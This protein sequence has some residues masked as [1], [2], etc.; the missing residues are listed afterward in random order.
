MINFFK[1]LFSK[2]QKQAPQDFTEEEY[3][4]G[5]DLKSKG[6]ENVLGRMHNLVGHALIPFSVGGAV[7]M[8]YFLNH[9]KGT[10]FATMELLEPDG[11]GPLP[12]RLGTYELVAFTKHEYDNNEDSKGA[13]NIIERKICG[14][15]TAIGFYSREAVL[16]PYDTCELPNGDGKEN[17]CL[18]FDLYEPG[19]KKFKVGDRQHHLLLCLQIFKSEM[20][21]ARGNG[22]EQLIDLLKQAG[23][24]PYSDLE[25]QPVV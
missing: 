9:I 18:L 12:N 3:E 19:S 7:D 14:L 4:Q 2:S 25:R 15:F 1:K 21:F 16:N 20:D 10:G 17:T 23:H 6:L 8:Y 5:Y 22:S 13:F 24:Y 11:T